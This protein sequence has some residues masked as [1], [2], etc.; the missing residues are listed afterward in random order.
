M[1]RAMLPRFREELRR[2]PVITTVSILWIANFAAMVTIDQTR[3]HW[4][5]LMPD[6]THTWPRHYRHS[7]T[8]YFTPPLG[9]Y[10]QFGFPVLLIV[11][12][13]LIVAELWLYRRGKSEQS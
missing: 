9:R 11:A 13:L 7:F 10:L 1:P 5:R 4:A 6:A 2:R 8:W 12:A 3:R